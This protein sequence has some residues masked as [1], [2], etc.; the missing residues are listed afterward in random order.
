MPQSTSISPDGQWFSLV[1]KDERFQPPAGVGIMHLDGTGFK[2]L[3][4]PP[5]WDKRWSPDGKALYF[6]KTEQGIGNVWKQAVAGGAPARV[7]NFSSGSIG[8]LAV[9]R[10]ERLAFRHFN[11]ISDVVLIRGVQ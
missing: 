3:N 1:Y 4:I 6:V 8:A 7:T 9:S 5:T 10:D 2:P 11:A